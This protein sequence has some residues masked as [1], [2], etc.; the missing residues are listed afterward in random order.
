MDDT[1]TLKENIY[2]DQMNILL[3]F[4]SIDMIHDFKASLSHKAWSRVKGPLDYRRGGRK[5]YKYL[6]KK[7]KENT[8]KEQ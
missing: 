3:A 1:T 8:Q 4:L 2:Q 6:K 7:K 5:K